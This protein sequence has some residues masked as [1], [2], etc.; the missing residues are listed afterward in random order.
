MNTQN[1]STDRPLLNRICRVTTLD[2]V[3]LTFA[4]LFL[5]GV[6]A[7]ALLA[8]VAIGDAPQ[9]RLWSILVSYAGIGFG[10][11][12]VAPWV[13]CRALH[14]ASHAAQITRERRKARPADPLAVLLQARVA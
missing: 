12:I 1:S 14:A 8:G 6:V 10:V 5:F 3:A 9:G 7:V 11:A 13:L 2:R 4:A